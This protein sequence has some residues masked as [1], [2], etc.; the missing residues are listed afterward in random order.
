MAFEWRRQ[1]HIMRHITGKAGL[2]SL[3]WS[4]AQNQIAQLQRLDKF[5]FKIWM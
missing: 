2:E 4:S 1:L 5:F 3:E